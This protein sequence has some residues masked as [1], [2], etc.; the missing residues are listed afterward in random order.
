MFQTG[1]Y[2]ANT[3]QGGYGKD[4]NCKEVEGLKQACKLTFLIGLFIL[5]RQLIFHNLSILCI[6]SFTTVSVQV[7]IV[8]T[9]LNLSGSF[10]KLSNNKSNLT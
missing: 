1:C 4:L 2:L 5:C 10:L 6:L 7:T 9:I 3:A 8:N